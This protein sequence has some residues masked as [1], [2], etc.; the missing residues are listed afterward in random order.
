MEQRIASSPG[1]SRRQIK[2]RCKSGIYVDEITLS[3]LL[4]VTHLPSG[5]A[6]QVLGLGITVRYHLL[7]VP[8]M[9]LCPP[10]AQ[11]FT[12]LLALQVFKKVCRMRGLE[13]WP[14]QKSSEVRPRVLGRLWRSTATCKTLARPHCHCATQ[15]LHFLSVHLTVS[16]AAGCGCGSERQ[17]QPG[18]SLL[19]QGRKPK[20][21]RPGAAPLGCNGEGR[22]TAEAGPSHR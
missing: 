6:A 2:K 15:S 17:W 21:G 4:S 10:V 14:Y 5:Q 7:L 3:D 11:H 8:A 20:P 1:R 9:L 16:V 12:A 13:R 22:G 19:Q 18:V